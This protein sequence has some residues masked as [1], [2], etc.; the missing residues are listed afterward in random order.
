MESDHRPSKYRRC[1]QPATVVRRG[2]SLLPMRAAVVPGERSAGSQVGAAR[3]GGCCTRAVGGCDTKAYPGIARQFRPVLGA[4]SR[5]NGSLRGEVDPTVKSIEAFY[6]GKASPANRKPLPISSSRRP[7]PHLHTHSRDV[8]EISH[9]E[10]KYPSEFNTAL[11]LTPLFP[12]R[13]V[14][15]RSPTIRGNNPPTPRPLR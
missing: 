9:R 14:V 15:P 2:L 3:H 8:L 11:I 12:R 7:A 4:L 10:A 6:R 5:A 13:G 1:P